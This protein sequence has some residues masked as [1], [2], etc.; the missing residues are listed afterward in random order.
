MATVAL[1]NAAEPVD[2]PGSGTGSV[3]KY[4]WETLTNSNTDGEAITLSGRAIHVSAQVVG[5]ADGATATLKG[6]WDGGTTWTTLPDQWGTD[7][8]M[9]ADGAIGAPGIIP[10]RIKPEL[11]GAGASTDLDFYLA[12]W[13]D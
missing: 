7:I 6:S 8:A 11:S 10:P 4:L 1:Q 2:G 3:S 5:T 9:A 12:L 13:M